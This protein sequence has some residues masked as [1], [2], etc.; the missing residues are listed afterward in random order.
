MNLTDQSTALTP[1][2]PRD[3]T[4]GERAE[5]SAALARLARGRGVVVRTADL[6]ANGLGSA[7][8]LGFRRLKL[9]RGLEQRMQGLALAL[10]ARAHD[11]AILGLNRPFSA[12]EQRQMT[13]AV[14]ASGAIGGAAGLAGF[15]PDASMTTLAIMRAIASEAL[16]QGEDLTTDTARQACLSV[17]LLQ[18]QPHAND[19]SQPLGSSETVTAVESALSYP[20][21]R[22]LLRG[23]PLTL[24]MSEAAARYGLTLS[25]KFVAQSV[26][27]IGAV[28]GATLN[29]AFLNHYRD[30]A[31]A[32]FTLRRI[33][34]SRNG[35]V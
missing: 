31:H 5:I 32:H 24:L 34:R 26:P 22:L 18:D 2:T 28:A 30:L 25:Q 19:S 6:L 21:A 1:T 35:S 27:L 23:Q 4:D 13:A 20:A 29:S 33:A 8:G 15:I 10:L 3:L 16:R 7:A 17:F 9:S 14:I 11:I 12:A